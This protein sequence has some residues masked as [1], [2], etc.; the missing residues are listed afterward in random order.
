MKFDRNVLQVHSTS[1]VMELEFG[2]IATLSR[3][4]PFPVVVLEGGRRGGGVS[5]AAAAGCYY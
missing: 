1:N 3:G 5:L 2:F 4:R